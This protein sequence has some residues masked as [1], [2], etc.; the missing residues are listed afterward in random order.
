MK[1]TLTLLITVLMAAMLFVSCDGNTS[2]TKTIHKV[3][4][5]TGKGGSDVASQ[6]VEDGKT[7]KKPAAVPG[8]TGYD[9]LRWS[10]TEDGE[11]AFD[12]DNTK[13]TENI[14]LY[15]VW[16]IKTC[17]VTFVTGTGASDVDSQSIEY[18][19]TAKK[20]AAVPGRTGYDFLRWSLTE[21]GETAFDFDNTK[22]TENIT[23]YAVWKIKTCT[24]TFVTGTGASD[25]DSQSI[26]YGK[27]AKKPAAVPGRTG[28][29][30]LRWSLTEDGETAFDF[31]NTK[32]TENITLY[33]V[34]KIKT[35]TVTFVTGTGASDVDS[36][37]I[38][39][40]KTAKK[41]AAVPGRT[42]YDFLRWSLTEDG[43]TDF[44][45]ANTK[46]TGNITLYAVWK[47]KTCTVTFVSGDGASVVDSQS[48]EYGKTA[49]KPAAPERTGYDLL[50]WSLTED[51]VTDFDFANTKITGNIT[52][53]AVWK[54]KTCTV[55]FVT[56][57]G[58]SNVDSQ[59][60][61]YGKTATKPA[62]VPERTGYDFLGWSVAVDGMTAFD[63][64]NTKITG[65]ITL[66]AVWKL[67]TYKAGDPGPA[68]GIV[69]YAA[70]K[71]QISKYT[72][73]S[74]KE[75]TLEWKYLEVAPQNV[76]GGTWGDDG[77][78][79]TENGVGTGWSNTRKLS[80]AGIDGFPA[81]KACVEYSTTVDGVRYD[82]WFLPSRDELNALWEARKS[83]SEM[84]AV[85]LSAENYWS[86]SEAGSDAAW[87]R[88]FYDGLEH[89]FYR[90]N[91]I[92]VRPVRAFLM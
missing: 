1:K 66:Y 65:N 73:S 8:R 12:F 20:P 33:A 76:S 2:T 50:R 57:T 68:G 43:V 53:Y 44:D 7:A 74:G 48:I 92:F 61:E 24:V 58:A 56:G 4:F 51:G 47:I 31:D 9:F 63:F 3:T 91:N 30:F 49:T 62:A 5:V 18:G 17:T 22:I 32:I 75:Q 28:Y 26:E 42:G 64:D 23:L 19:K 25:V 78:Y 21:D 34:W 84:E 41:P 79:S 45:F 6:S 36:Q 60:I 72:D 77:S 39:Y 80:A 37:S 81:A 83:S 27:T 11:T 86:S 90:F 70:D 52:L 69:F 15:A 29:D 46:I 10:L 55:T 40:G 13:I 67:K 38:E 87:A 16:K 71:T 14:T 35:C 59:S 88:N 85:S 54:T 82:D 89:N